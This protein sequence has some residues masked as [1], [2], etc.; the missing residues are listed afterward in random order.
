MSR[1]TA[2]RPLKCPTCRSTDLV[3]TSSEQYR[4]VKGKK[5]LVADVECMTCGH[6]W[7]SVSKIARRMAREAD[8]E[9]VAAVNWPE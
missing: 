1:R 3:A 4:T 2:S 5:R 9:R 8:A 6:A 7:W